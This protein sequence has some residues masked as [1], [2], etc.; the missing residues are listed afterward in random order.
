MGFVCPSPFA[1]GP[2]L[3]ALREATPGRDCPHSPAAWWCPTPRSCSPPCRPWP[4]CHP[5]P[6]LGTWCHQWGP[7]HPSGLR[8]Q[9]LLPGAKGRPLPG[10]PYPWGLMWLVHSRPLLQLGPSSSTLCWG[11]G[12]QGLLSRHCV[13]P[14]ARPARCH[15]GLEGPGALPYR[16]GLWVPGLGQDACVTCLPG[17][18]G[19]LWLTPLPGAQ[20]GSFPGCGYGTFWPRAWQHGGQEATGLHTEPSEAWISSPPATLGSRLVGTLSW[21]WR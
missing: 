8:P 13:Q 19:H 17:R 1:P 4:L 2:D 12:V 20:E 10:S 9:A 15:V 14:W 21:P 7:R 18:A 5:S 11:L 6:S 3:V 16:Q